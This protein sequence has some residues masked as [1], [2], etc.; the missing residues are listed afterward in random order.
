LMEL[1]VL[2]KLLKITKK[3]RNVFDCFYFE[4]K[5]ISV[6]EVKNL[7]IEEF[8]KLIP[9]F[10]HLSQISSTINPIKITLY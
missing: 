10:T 3:I 8:K 9:E 7:V 1:R 6:N 2:N 4:S 5:S